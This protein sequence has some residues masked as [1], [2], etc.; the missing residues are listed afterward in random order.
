MTEMGPETK[1]WLFV[2]EYSTIYWN[3]FLLKVTSNGYSIKAKIT[4]KEK[5]FLKVVHCFSSF[6]QR[7]NIY[8]NHWKQLGVA[9]E[10]VKSNQKDT[11]I[12]ML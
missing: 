2:N 5:R 3:N 8:V 9:I 4:L 10:N 6:M 1:T 7:N 11:R 12:S